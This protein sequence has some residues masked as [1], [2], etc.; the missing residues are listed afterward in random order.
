MYLNAEGNTCRLCCWAQVLN[1]TG[2]SGSLLA[3]GKTYYVT[4]IATN[5]GGPRL[6]SN[7][8]SGPVRLDFLA[9][10]PGN[11]YN[12]WVMRGCRAA[13]LCCLLRHGSE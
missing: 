6:V 8:S 3:N 7:V 10:V 4:V 1:I 5:R 13:G 11:V 12:T 2:T 9:A